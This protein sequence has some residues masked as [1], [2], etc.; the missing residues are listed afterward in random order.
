MIPVVT[1]M[2]DRGMGL[3]YQRTEFV[4]LAGLGI[5]VKIRGT[6]VTLGTRF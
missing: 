4:I 2:T 5:S 3:A 1:Q 6:G